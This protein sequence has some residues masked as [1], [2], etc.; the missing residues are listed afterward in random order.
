[1]KFDWT[2]IPQELGLATVFSCPPCK[3]SEALLLASDFLGR[4][5]QDGTIDF[6]QAVFKWFRSSFSALP[7]VDHPGQGERL[8]L[9]CSR[10]AEYPGAFTDGG[11]GCQDVIDEQ[12]APASHLFGC[13]NLEGP[14]HI[15]A[16]FFS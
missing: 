13:V 1:M 11:A 6:P 12:H 9:R 4:A 7:S 8:H 2:Y 10:P 15:E 3:K 14:L 16:A 5:L